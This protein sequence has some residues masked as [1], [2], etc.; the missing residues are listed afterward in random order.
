[1]SFDNYAAT[2]EESLNSGLALSGEGSAYFAETRI[3]C[4]GAFLK[5]D[6]RSVTRVVDFGCGTGNSIP[7]IR[8]YIAP[9]NIIGLDSSMDYMAIQIPILLALMIMLLKEKTT[10]CIVMEFFIIFYL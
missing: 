4:L 10:W 6:N 9:E 3:K 2:Y 1:M 5:R 8:K 7:F